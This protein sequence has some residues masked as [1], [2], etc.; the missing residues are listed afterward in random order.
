MG[1]EDESFIPPEDFNQHENSNWS[2]V[3]CST[4]AQYYHILRRQLRREFRKPLIVVA[5]KKMLK[6][7][8][9]QSSIEEFGE[10]RR[11]HRVL[12][13][14]FPD[15]INQADKIKKVVLCSG[16]VH[17]ELAKAREDAKVKD[18]ALVRIEELHP[19]PYKKL[20]PILAKYKNAKVVWT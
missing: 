3:N 9:A 4:A 1:D 5:P 10:N 12:D 20:R 8:D 19:F 14:A 15:K 13:D 11:F 7:K 6:S 17:H 16:Q 18:V 2:V